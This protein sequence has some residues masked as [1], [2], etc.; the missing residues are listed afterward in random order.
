MSST[1]LLKLNVFFKL[2][3]IYINR[4]WWVSLN[5]VLARPLVIRAPL[6]N[7]NKSKDSEFWQGQSSFSGN[8]KICNLTFLKE[9]MWFQTNAQTIGSHVCLILHVYKWWSINVLYLNQANVPPSCCWN[10]VL[11]CLT[12]SGHWTSNLWHMGTGC[13]NE[14]GKISNNW[15]LIRVGEFYVYM[16]NV[17]LYL[18][19]FPC[20]NLHYNELRRILPCFISVQ[21]LVLRRQWPLLAK[22]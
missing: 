3:C 11:H 12:Q 5:S 20:G 8:L 21:V 6:K 16:F 9:K 10:K 17:H 15:V 19:G 22:Y 7:V 13:F 2:V 14:N 4:Y 1:A 18:V